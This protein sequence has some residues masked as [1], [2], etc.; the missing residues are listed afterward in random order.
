MK[1]ILYLL[2]LIL[3][4]T[5]VGCEKPDDNKNDNNEDGINA[6]VKDY[7]FYY[8]EANIKD[9]WKTWFNLDFYKQG[10][11]K[12]RFIK[13]SIDE[14]ISKIDS[15]E[16]FVIYY[17]FD[18]TLYRCP[19]CVCSLPYAE[20]IAEELD[21]YIYYVDVYVARQQDSEEYH[22]LYDPISAAFENYAYLAE[23]DMLR[24]STVV[25]YKDGKPFNFNLSTIK[26][27]DNK[28]I[29]DLTEEQKEQLKDIYRNLFTGK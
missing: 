25:Y 24:A 16:S 15:G 20:M 10:L 2:I 6:F 23:G 28:N 8:D 3:A 26:D 13:I 5:F 19:N 29:L 9:N 22:K 12:K 18:P 4:V 1:K 14:A 21:M 27:A 17:A 11:E 7:E